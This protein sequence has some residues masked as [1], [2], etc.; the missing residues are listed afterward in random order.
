LKKIIIVGGKGGGVKRGGI[1]N[2]G[3]DEYAKLKVGGEEV[4]RTAQAEKQP[5]QYFYQECK[6]ASCLH[7]STQ[8]RGGL[9][10]AG[11]Q[12]PQVY[13]IFFRS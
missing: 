11:L 9:F 7:A 4:G 10:E 3:V 1:Q 12:G 2:Q 13:L 5:T 8:G 6:I